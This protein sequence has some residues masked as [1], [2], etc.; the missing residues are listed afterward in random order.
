[1]FN[2]SL[3]FELGVMKDRAESLLRRV[4]HDIT[5]YTEASRLR[6]FLSYFAPISEE[7]IPST[8]LLREFLGGSS[9]KY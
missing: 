7:F 6:T 9:F 3:L 4:P 5:E 8:S 2:S 1:M